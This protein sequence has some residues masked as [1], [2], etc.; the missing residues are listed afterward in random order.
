MKHALGISVFQVEW[1]LD[2]YLLTMYIILLAML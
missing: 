2:H 1:L